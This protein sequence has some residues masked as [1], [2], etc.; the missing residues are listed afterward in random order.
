MT[1]YPDSPEFLN[2]ARDAGENF[3]ENIYVITVL[4][5]HLKKI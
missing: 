4:G 3:P 1:F 5:G 2:G